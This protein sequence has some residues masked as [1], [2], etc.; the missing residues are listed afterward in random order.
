MWCFN[1]PDESMSCAGAFMGLQEAWSLALDGA[2][3]M[4]SIPVASET[5]LV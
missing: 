1:A 3:P 5:I 2:V 4:L